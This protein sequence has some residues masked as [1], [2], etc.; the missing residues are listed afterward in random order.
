M[1]ILSNRGE[2]MR[3]IQTRLISTTWFVVTNTSVFEERNSHARSVT[4]TKRRERKRERERREL[5]QRSTSPLFLSSPLPSSCSFSLPTWHTQTQRA[6][7]PAFS[8]VRN[9]HNLFLPFFVFVSVVRYTRVLSKD[10][11]VGVELL[12]HGLRLGRTLFKRY[13][14]VSHD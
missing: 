10:G 6:H 5:F 14:N 7:R 12:H 3:E 4:R 1:Q 11:E 9:Q 13:C 2:E 8:T